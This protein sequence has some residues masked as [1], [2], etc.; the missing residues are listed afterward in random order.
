MAM[1]A[2]PGPAVAD[3]DDR[4]VAAGWRHWPRLS[5]VVLLVGLVVTAGLSTLSRLNY[6]SNE[7]R[8]V[9]AQAQLAGAALAVAPVDLQRRLGRA[10]TAVAA[11]GNARLFDTAMSASLPKPFVSA[12]LFQ[13]VRGVPRLVTTL[14]QAPLLAPSSAQARQVLEHALGGSLAVTRMV[15][16]NA[17]RMGYAMAVTTLGRTYVSYAEQVLSADRRA[18]IP[19]GSALDNMDFA[20]Y[21]GTAETP[22][23]LVETN[24]AD[25]P[26]RGSR[27]TATIPFGDSTVTLVLSPRSPLLG[28]FAASVSWLIAAAGVLLTAVMALLIER[29]ARRRAVAEEL[30]TVAGELY[31][32]QHG[33]AETLQT[34]L[35]P[36]HLPQMPGLAVASRYL[37]GTEGI[38]VGGDWYDLISL[39]DDRMFFTV[40]DVSG[41]G[42]SAATMMSRLRHTITAYAVEGAH[43]AIVL[44][45]VS[46]LIDLERDGHFATALCGVIDR[47]SGS[48][49]IANAGHPPPVCI[50]EDGAHPI[51]APVGPPLGVGNQYQE[52]TIALNPGAVVLAYTD[53]LIERR[54]ETIDAGI[55][56]L[57]D[58][59]ATATDLETLLDAVLSALMPDGAAEDDTAILAL[60]WTRQ[61]C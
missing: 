38:D 2:V 6:V 22:S 9:S 1:D 61:T 13:V 36:H 51:Q 32:T 47:A 23:A 21:Y 59:A 26:I 4:P 31:R 20:L 16:A 55:A 52:T 12:E 11:T 35:L 15:T 7:Q 39:A 57:C 37:A 10:S 58:V 60:Q 8:L 30:A 40:G 48:V 18:T 29:L 45:K 25:L 17:Q 50:S 27:G 19:R 42:L 43:P 34:A 14:G 33:V 46:A 3:R 24:A 49:T 41:R 5:L 28:T 44:A 56:R 54:G 53:G